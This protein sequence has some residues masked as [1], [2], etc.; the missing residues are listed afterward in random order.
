MCYYT[1]EV[2]MTNKC[3]SVVGHFNGHARHGCNRV[4]IAWWRMSR[5]LLE[6]TGC[7]HRV[8]TCFVLPQGLHRSHSKQRQWKNTPTLLSIM[9][10][11]A[12]RQY[13]TLHITQYWRP[14]ASLEAIGCRHWASQPDI[15]NWSSIRWFFVLFFIV[16]L[17]EM[18]SWWC[19]SPY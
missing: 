18:G 12:M 9:M 16:N 10:V 5:A 3:N 7:R 2:D 1:K 6:A 14:R 15:I 4:C 8:T 13:Y 19:Q 17:L 11:M